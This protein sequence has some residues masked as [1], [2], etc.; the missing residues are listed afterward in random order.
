[1]PSYVVRNEKFRDEVLK[2]AYP[3][4]EQSELETEELFIGTDLFVDAVFYVKVDAELPLYV[5]VVDG[6]AEALDQVKFIIYDSDG[7][8]VGECIAD[9]ESEA[10][11]VFHRGLPV[12]AIVFD[13]DGLKRFI[14]RVS[15]KVVPLLSDVAQFL[16][17]CCHVSRATHL[18]AVG[19][20][21]LVSGDVKIVARRGC[22]FVQEGDGSLRL[23]IVAG[24]EAL[25][26]R[27]PV[28]SIN[29]VRN[30]SIW[31]ANHPRANL[32]ISNE[33]GQLTFA[34]AKDLT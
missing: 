11:Q 5:G 17:D 29:G 34:Q 7:N 18:R 24:N 1:M 32:R 31:L 16:L 33:N 26:S 22:R 10:V 12:G 14:G 25:D 3:F 4:D 23:D 21:S 28:V 9:T 13:P 19:A 30:T 15:G 6:T 2:Y 27:Q 20:D 8:N